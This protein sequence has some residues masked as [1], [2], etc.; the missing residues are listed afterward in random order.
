MNTTVSKS[1]TTGDNAIN[2]LIAKVIDKFD[3]NNDKQLNAS[4]FGSFLQGLLG[5]TSGIK[6]MS[7]EGDASA[8]ATPEVAKEFNPTPCNFG[9]LHGFAADNYY[10][11]DMNSM[12]YKFARIAADYDPR[13]AGAA[14][15]LVADPRFAKEFP[16][17]KL[18]GKDCID[19]A[20]QLSDGAR[21]VPV[22][23]VDVGEAFTDQ[24]CG[25]AWQ[26]L[27]SGNLTAAAKTS[28]T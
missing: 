22:G 13:Q 24:C 21:G 19:F 15:R 14:E 17:A 27:D 23:L 26:W 8:D 28:N 5:G 9:L 12:K 3:T 18:V 1:T 11:K 2:D 10:N 7:L 16:N 4:E 20:G 25:V 6:S